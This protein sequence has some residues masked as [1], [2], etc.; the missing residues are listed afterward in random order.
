LVRARKPT[1]SAAAQTTPPAVAVE[2]QGSGD[3]DD[4]Q[5]FR[6]HATNVPDRYAPA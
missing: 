6:A 3:D 2:G 4:Q 1:M 5:Q